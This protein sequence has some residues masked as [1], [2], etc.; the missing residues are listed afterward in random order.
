MDEFATT[1]IRAGHGRATEGYPWPNAGVTNLDRIKQAVWDAFRGTAQTTFEQ[2]LRIRLDE[3]GWQVGSL[4]RCARLLRE[5]RA[6]RRR[7]R[8]RRPAS[9]PPDPLRGLRPERRVGAL[10]RPSGRAG[11]RSLAGRAHAR[12]RTPRPAYDAV[13]SDD[14][15]DRRQVR[16]TMRSWR[17]STVVDGARR[18]SGAPT[19]PEPRR[20]V[21]LPR[22]GRRGRGL[23]RGRVPTP[24]G[25]PRRAG[26]RRVGAARGPSEEVRPLP[27]AAPLPGPLRL[28]D[29]LPSRREPDR[30]RACQAARSPSTAPGRRQSERFRSAGCKRRRQCAILRH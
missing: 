25:P 19:A 29:P 26:P 5:R 16:R 11:P 6:S 27:V 2:G 18:R 15:A 12:R 30:R 14:R 22:F 21:E 9:T 10:L 28:L 17:H 24:R 3:V 8:R 7:P 4:E 1:P 13:K 20:L 23:R